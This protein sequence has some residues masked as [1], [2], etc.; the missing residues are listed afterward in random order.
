MD[1]KRKRHW[2]K[3]RSDKCKMYLRNDFRF[4]CAYCRVREQ[5][6]ACGEAY[7]E[8]DHFVPRGSSEEND[9]DSYDNIVYSCE[10]CNR[11]KSN[12]NISLILDPCRDDIY[13]GDNPHIR[14]TGAENQ[15]RLQA[16][17]E[18]GQAFID[19]LQLNSRFYREARQK[20]EKNEYVRN[21]MITLLKDN[22]TDNVPEAVLTLIKYLDD[23]EESF[24]T[25]E[26]RCGFSKAG[27]RLYLVL[28]ELEKR[29]IIHQLL[30]GDDDLDIT[31]E[32]QGNTYYCEVL[33]SDFMGTD[34][35]KPRILNEKA[36][37]W[38]KSGKDCGVLCYYGNTGVLKLFMF[39][40]KKGLDESI[41][42]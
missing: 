40:S 35:R 39:Q 31:L 20:Q 32:W 18:K 14:K 12:Q 17:T 5:D 19:A 10:K 13:G 3:Y 21:A 27:E 22:F 41:I 26:F 36:E 6:N 16:V 29:G 1:Y 25:D 30:L 28:K 42:L 38:E 37:A 8:M 23:V 11:T 7:F 33:T 15:Y 34:G 2:V 4:E 24:L 9:S